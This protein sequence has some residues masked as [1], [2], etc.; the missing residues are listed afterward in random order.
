MDDYDGLPN[1]TGSGGTLPVT[2]R[3]GLGLTLSIN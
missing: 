3:A 1:K 2:R